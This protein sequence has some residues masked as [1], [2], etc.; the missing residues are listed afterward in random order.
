MPNGYPRTTAWVKQPRDDARPEGARS[1]NPRYVTSDSPLTPSVAA[2]N[3]EVRRVWDA[4]RAGKP[5]RVPMILGVNPRYTT[6]DHPANPR[7]LTIEESW[8]DPQLMLERQ[9]EHLE[10]CAFNLPQDAEMG[11]PE[12]WR[13]GVEFQNVYEAAG[14]GCPI[15]YYDNQV[16]DTQPILGEWHG[17]PARGLDDRLGH[18]RSVAADPFASPFWTKVWAY[19][20]HYKKREAEGFEWRGRPIK[21][22]GVCGLGTDGPLTVA[23]NVRGASEFC[24]DLIEDPGFADDLLALLTE[25]AA[26]RIKAFRQRLGLPLVEKGFGY[27]DDSIALL[28]TEMVFERIVPHHRR[29]IEAFAPDSLPQSSILNPQSSN[30]IHLCGNA[31]RH[32]PML[33]RE[34]NIKSFDTGFPVDFGA[35]RRDLG[36]DVEI[37][38][39]PSVPFLVQATAEETR[40]ETLRIL[41]SGITAGGRFILRE[42]NNLAPEVPLANCQAMYEAVKQYGRY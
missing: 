27:A 13:V 15:Q 25:S 20:D 11:L 8:S 28:S 21:V 10:W 38:G 36:E 40:A 32:F 2:H 3:E 17:R 22:G 31:T 37:L 9:L 35:L 34:L 23:C 18:L 24:L 30:S 19:Y 6:F 41:G 1:G 39:G 5:I 33:K 16:P 42:G 14:L 4:Y 12:A 7:K 29:L 26:V